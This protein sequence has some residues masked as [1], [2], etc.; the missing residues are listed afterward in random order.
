LK[1]KHREMLEEIITAKMQGEDSMRELE[2][3]LERLS[4]VPLHRSF[5]DDIVH[6][7]LSLSLLF[8]IPCSLYDSLVL[9]TVNMCVHVACM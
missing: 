1:S 6:Y 5:M 8:S 7:S 4:G 2:Q 9:L 3:I